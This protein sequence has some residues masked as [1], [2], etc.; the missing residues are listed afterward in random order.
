MFTLEYTNDYGTLSFGGGSHPVWNITKISGLGL[1]E[2][3]ITH[4]NFKGE[5]GR[6]TT[7]MTL[8]ERTI[9]MAGDIISSDLTKEI[10]WAISI[11]SHE[12]DI[13]INKN[14]LIHC[15]SVI[16]PDPERCGKTAKFTMQFICDE[17]YFGETD[18]IT[19]S[20]L[21]VENHITGTFSLPLVFSTLKT[22]GTIDI[23]GDSKTA[24]IIYITNIGTESDERIVIKNEDTTKSISLN[25]FPKIDEIIEIDI[26]KRTVTGS[27]AGQLLH[28]IAPETHL[29]EF[30]LHYG[31]NRISLENN[32]EGI[33]I[34]VKYR[35]KYAC[36]IY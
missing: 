35:N 12:G 32:L 36:A 14:R 26:D 24:P 17:P 20:V 29:S 25:Y 22:S 31:E 1:T 4:V 2:K 8:K 7:D 3:N 6:L 15:N 11:L 16:F 19:S 30:Y 9:T 18:Y 23:S 34:T 5:D 28:F 27:I 33:N 21:D 13:V 10:S